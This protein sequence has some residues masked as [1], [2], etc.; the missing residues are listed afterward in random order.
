MISNTVVV[1]LRDMLPLFILIAYLSSIG[2]MQSLDKKWLKLTLFA[3]VT[4]VV[5]F[6]FNFE[7]IAE[8]FE[9]RGY[10]IVSS[11]ILCLFFICCAS[12]SIFSGMLPSTYQKWLLA[13]GIVLLVT[14]KATEFMVY[15]GVFIQQSGDLISICLG[16]L[17]GISIC[18]SFHLLYR[19]FLTE[20]IAHNKIKT[21]YMLW[22][23]FI[24]GQIVQ[25]PERLSQ[26]DIIDLG[27]P[28]FNLSEF[29]RDSSEYG[30]VLN[31]LLGYES[32]PTTTF[33][34]AYL[35]SFFLLLVISGAA[36]R[37]AGLPISQYF[38][39]ESK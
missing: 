8:S 33:I 1:L 12:V 7:L 34:G 14:L 36:A 22:F 39:G 20:L 17:M 38:S 6:Y 13:V 3:A 2:V 9:G 18:I 19:F 24:T 26:V 11:L 16:F 15:F 35:C 5:A 25:I 31:A 10:E 37:N 29:V 28:L 21:V 23:A 27:K 4:S 30:H 32:S